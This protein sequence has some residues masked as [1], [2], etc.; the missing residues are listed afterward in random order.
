MAERTDRLAALETGLA[1]VEG[2]LAELRAEREA[3]ARPGDDEPVSRRRMLRRLGGA[4]AAGTAAAVGATLAGAGPAAGSDPN[5]VVKG[6]PNF[7]GAA[8][9]RL[10]STSSG[11]TL[12][13][14]NEFQEAGAFANAINAS[15]TDPDGF[16]DAIRGL[17]WGWGAGVHAIGNTVNSVGLH[18]QGGR[19]PLHIQQGTTQGAPT[20]PRHARG[21]IYLDSVGALF[22]CVTGGD[23]GGATP[24][25]VR[26]G[27]NPVTPFRVADTR[28]GTGTPY[29][30]A[31]L[32]PGATR[33]VT[34]AGVAGTGVP[35]TGANAAVFNVTVTNGGASGYLTVYP[36]G[37]PRPVV[38]SVNWAPNGT[39][40]NYVTM[41]LGANGGVDIFNGSLSPV[42]LIVDVTGFFS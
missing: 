2:E 15:T 39:V 17:T 31:S 28:A 33:T 21:E 41:K 29:S 13:V 22:V 20:S 27:F 34:I 35:A 42:D 12:D 38:S 1:R 36:S 10:S 11:A 18:C 3:L 19:A 24:T 16:N 23:V 9:T 32:A 14:T 8:T 25:W 40:A 26:I 37:T 4:A 5:D 6:A 30:G 7:A